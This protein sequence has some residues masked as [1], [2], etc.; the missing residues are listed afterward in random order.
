MMDMIGFLGTL[1]YDPLAFQYENALDAV[2]VIASSG[3][4]ALIILSMIN[5]TL[6]YSVFGPWLEV[7]Y[8]LLL[9]AVQAPLIHYPLCLVIL[10]GCCIAREFHLNTEKVS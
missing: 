5:K 3:V 7:L 10:W 2:R 9:S 4:T 6:L 1:W 8:I